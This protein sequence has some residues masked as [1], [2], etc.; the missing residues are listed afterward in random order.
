VPG[1]RVVGGV[2]H[3]QH[4]HAYHQRLKEW[5]RHFNGVATKYL[6]IYLRW[7]VFLEAT[8]EFAGPVAR[9]RLL[10]DACAA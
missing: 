3:I 1:T 4:I 8:K 2:H 5:M 7:H 6:D 9:D 10:L